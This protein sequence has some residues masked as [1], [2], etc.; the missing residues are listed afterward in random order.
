MGSIPDSFLLKDFLDP[1][2]DRFL[3]IPGQ[4]FVLFSLVY[5]TSS[6]YGFWNRD[7]NMKLERLTKNNFCLTLGVS[8]LFDILPTQQDKL[9]NYN[10]S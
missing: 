3:G 6:Y 5:G 8:N 4:G 10:R 2:L 9:R 1:N 7:L